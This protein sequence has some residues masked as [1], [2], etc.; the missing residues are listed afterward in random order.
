MTQ[1][2]RSRGWGTTLSSSRATPV[3]LLTLI[4]GRASATG[5]RDRPRRGCA[6]GVPA[7][8]AHPYARARRRSMITTS[9]PA[10][11][12]NGPQ[13]A[14]HGFPPRGRATTLLGQ[15]DRDACRRCAPSGAIS[16]SR[17]GASRAL[18]RRA[19]RKDMA[20]NKNIGGRK[21][22]KAP[23]AA[24]RACKRPTIRSGSD[25]DHGKHLLAPRRTPP[26]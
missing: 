7:F 3:T 11:R 9:A 23:T 19:R 18:G 22:P 13:T 4:G 25:L 5:A 15:A 20:V 17:S 21:G 16:A 2:S 6:R 14:F 12:R 1:R 10:W 26:M 24:H 8:L